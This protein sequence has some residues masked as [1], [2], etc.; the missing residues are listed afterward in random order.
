MPTL[1]GPSGP[2][3]YQRDEWGYPRARVKDHEEGMWVLGWFHARDRSFQVLLNRVASQGRLMEFVGDLPYTRA[4]DQATRALAFNRDLEPQLARVDAGS[5]RIGRRYCEG[6]A[7]GL[8][9]R[10]MPLP[11]GLIGLPTEPLGLADLLAAVR[12]LGWFGLN[13]LTLTSATTV[14]QLAS[15]GATAKDLELLLGARAEGIDLEAAQGCRWPAHMIGQFSS[16]AHGSNAFGVAARK[17]ATG[18]ALLMAEFHMEVGRLPPLLYAAHLDFED[19]GFL[20]GVSVP[21]LPAI[22]AGRTREVGWTY[23][24]GH[25]GNAEVWIERCRAGAV[26]EPDGSETRLDQRIEQLEVRGRRESETMTFWDGPRGT[27]HGDARAGGDLP[28]IRWRGLDQVHADMDAL[29]QVPASRDVDEL[30]ALHRRTRC[31]S[32]AG[33]FVDR[34]GRI[35]YCQTGSVGETEHWGPRRGWVDADPPDVDESQRPCLV[36]PPS[37]YVTSA[38]EPH[39]G[40]TAFAEPR[41]RVQ[42]L[43]ALMER[44]DRLTP[45]DLRLASYDEHDGMAARLLPVWLPLLPAGLWTDQLRAWSEAQVGADEAPRGRPLLAMRRRVLAFFHLLHRLAMH[46]LLSEH[47][48]HVGLAD[49]VMADHSLLLGIQNRMDDL[50]ALEVPARLDEST[51]RG[52]LA[53]AF[54]RAEQLEPDPGSWSP[55]RRRA[56]LVDGISDGK[57]PLILG[58]STTEFELPGGPVCPFQSRVTIVRGREV[59]TGP[60]FHLLMDMGDDTTRYNVAGGAYPGRWGEGYARGVGDWRRGVLAPLGGPFP[61]TRGP[62]ST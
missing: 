15:G 1:P 6:F 8:A 48:S 39:P 10:R 53:R 11:A 23:T 52:I 30:V 22:V 4:M 61:S 46:E 32:L 5:R 12:L 27:I 49:A 33:T 36:D 38:N 57:I 37:G 56:R 54:A 42:R 16:A 14:A 40:W 47:L 35:A 2:I 26:L 58:L 9:S 19:G 17:S 31:L 3:E 29:L 34:A 20:H 62:G 13:S 60:A 59:L 55:A 28:G 50:L 18:S 43:S 45:E 51:L 41:Y 7:A 24:F 21:G 25:A 44:S